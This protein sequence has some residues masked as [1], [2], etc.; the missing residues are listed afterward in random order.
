MITISRP[1]NCAYFSPEQKN[2]LITNYSLTLLLAYTGH[3]RGEA[4]GLTWNDLDLKNK[5]VIVKPTRDSY[6]PRSPKTKNSYRTVLMDDI[7]FQQL[8]KY[9]TWCK[10]MKLKNGARL[11]DD[12]YIFISYQKGTSAGSVIIVDCFERLHMA[13]ADYPMRPF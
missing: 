3:C 12:D 4:L 7:V 6:G 5:T 10:E 9:K 11:I 13:K 1:Q 8:E 2:K